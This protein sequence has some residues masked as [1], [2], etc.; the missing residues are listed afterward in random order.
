MHHGLIFLSFHLTLQVMNSTA[1]AAPS[2][3]GRLLAHPVLQ[4][5]DHAAPSSKQY[6][7]LHYNEQTASPS[8]SPSSEITHTSVWNIEMMRLL[9]CMIH[10]GKCF[11]LSNLQVI[12][13]QLFFLHLIILMFAEW[14]SMTQCQRQ[15]PGFVV[16]SYQSQ[17]R[18]CLGHKVTVSSFCLGCFLESWCK[19]RCCKQCAWLFIKQ[20][21]H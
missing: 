18:R 14:F 5:H 15:R 7:L 10:W 1:V 2:A 4:A 6:V 3:A 11:P 9:A 8:L 17:E 16:N 21:P 13:W 20:M 12:S 19:K